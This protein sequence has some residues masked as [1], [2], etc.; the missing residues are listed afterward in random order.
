MNGGR[1]NDDFNNGDDVRVVC[2]GRV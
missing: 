2:G 1:I